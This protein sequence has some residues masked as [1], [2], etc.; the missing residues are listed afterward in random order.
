MNHLL[1]KGMRKM[2][3]IPDKN[4]L[5]D[6]FRSNPKNEFPKTTINRH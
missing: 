5:E 3:K 1:S 2:P 6:L 4:H